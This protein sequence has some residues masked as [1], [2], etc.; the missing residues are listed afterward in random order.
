MTTPSQHPQPTP[1]RILEALNAFQLTETLKAAIELDIFTAIAEGADTAAALAKRCH[2]AERGV[3]ILCDFL[4]VRE[5][6]L[7]AEGRYSLPPDSAAFLDRRSPACI[8]SCAKFLDAF[9]LTDAHRNLATAVRK[10]GTALEGNGLMAPNHPI[11]V[12]YAR[13]MAPLQAMPAELI[14]RLL[15]A[16]TG[17]NWKVLDIA[18]GHGLFGVTLAKHNPNAEIYALDSP[19]VLAVAQENA[20]KAGVAARHHA[21]PGDAFTTEF[22][23]DYDLILVTNFLHGCD[24]SSVEKLTRKVHSALK[25][26]GR[27][28]TLEWIPNE[29][30]ISPPRPAA[31][32]LN[33]LVATREGD[34]YTFAEYQRMFRNAGFTSNELHPLPVTSSV[35]IS[36]K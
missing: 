31:F 28:V 34:A 14:A 6:L 17:T 23:Q 33:M 21:I 19:G 30:R 8:A 5:F 35:I 26:G 36:T 29:D 18:A 27:A 16:D 4:T 3:R 32:A 9:E 13:S 1:E 22:G 7:K 25:P 11:W 15:Q 2:A 24:V 20:T 12:E 10:G